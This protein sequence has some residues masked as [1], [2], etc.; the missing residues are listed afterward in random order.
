M[1]GLG[2]A[3]GRIAADLVAAGCAVRGGT[4]RGPRQ[5]RMPRA[6]SSASGAP[7][8][9]S[10]STP[11]PSR[12]T[13]QPA[14]AGALGARRALRRL[15]HCVA[16]SS[17]GSSPRRAGAASPTSRSSARSRALGPRRRRWRRARARSASPRSS[18]PSGCRSR[19]S[20]LDPGD[21]AGL[22]LL[23]S[24]FM[25]GIAAA[26]VETLEAAGPPGRRT[27]PRRPRRCHRRAVARAPAMSG[28]R[29][30]AARHDDEMRAVDY[31]CELGVARTSLR[32]RRTCSSSCATR[33]D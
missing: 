33:A 3:G 6:V 10:A 30:H 1:L 31:V 22:K 18:G 32:P 25:K 11:P 9:F 8:S 14:V 29:A 5:S 20:A 23:R 4:P 16:R 28:T 26:A 12:S 15:Q 17:S 27:P 2:E 21:A 7:T 24:V 19:S 13:P